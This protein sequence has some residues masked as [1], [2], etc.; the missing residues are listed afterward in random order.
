MGP[1]GCSET[2]VRIYPYSLHNNQ[3]NA[4]LVALL[5][6]GKMKYTFALE[7]LYRLTIQLTTQNNGTHHVNMQTCCHG[8]AD[9]SF[10]Y[11]WQHPAWRTGISVSYKEMSET[12]ITRGNPLFVRRHKIKDHL[13]FTLSDRAQ[14]P[15][16]YFQRY[17]YIYSLN[18]P[19]SLPGRKVHF[20]LRQINYKDNNL[21]DICCSVAFECDDIRLLTPDTVQT[22]K[23]LQVF[24]RNIFAFHHTADKLSAPIMEAAGPNGRAV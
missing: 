13:Y 1:I 20:V 2:S 15:L 18:P 5:L 24:G 21:S 12:W 9:Y 7:K 4:V 6:T 14:V 10:R 8:T 16:P 11:L 22:D 23:C 19:G 3:E 17:N